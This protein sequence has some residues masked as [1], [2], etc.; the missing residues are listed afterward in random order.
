MTT[1]LMLT[2][3]VSLV[4]IRLSVLDLE[5]T[6]VLFT[7]SDLT[8]TFDPATLT[9]IKIKV[10]NNVNLMCKNNQ[11]SFTLLAIIDPQKSPFNA[12]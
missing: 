9:L 11:D 7:N 8:L 1:L 2:F 10:F 12:Y 4:K 5:L 6:Q 3:N